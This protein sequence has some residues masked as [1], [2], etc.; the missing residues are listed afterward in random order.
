MPSSYSTT[1]QI[2]REEG[3]GTLWDF[4]NFR[5]TKPCVKRVFGRV[6]ILSVKNISLMIVTL[7]KVQNVNDLK[8]D[9]NQQNTLQVLA[10]MFTLAMKLLE[11][12]LM[13]QWRNQQWKNQQ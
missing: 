11:E 1:I 4:A 13:G 2:L 3:S 5:G 12:L 6:E 7:V 8:K 10:K 9:Q